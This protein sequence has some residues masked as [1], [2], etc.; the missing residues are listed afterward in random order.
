MEFWSLSHL[1]EAVKVGILNVGCIG[2]APLIDYLIDER[3]EIEDIEVRIVGTGSKM[4]PDKALEASQQLSSYKPTFAIVISP[5]ASLPGPKIAR[6]TLLKA[7]IPTIVVSDSPARRI[8]KDLESSGFGYVILEADAMIGAR[9]EFLD[10]NE[11][12]FFNG[13]VLRVLAITGSLR[14]A[15][16][17]LDRVVAAAKKGEKISLPKLFVDQ[18]R[19]LGESGLRNPYAVAKAMAAHE[20]A[21]RVSGISSDACFV[22]KEWE[23]YTPMV[24]SAHEMMRA[25]ARLADEAREIEKGQDTVLR[26][27]H[28]RDGTLLHKSRLMEK[29]A[30]KKS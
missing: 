19:A 13:D 27:P 9:R 26:Q 21:R 20:I 2:T 7:G 5:N 15:I 14:A 28:G 29:P 23:K 1:S 22:V 16:N 25:A 12:A 8:V 24:A 6:E 10:P 11:V 18:E 3:A 17:A 4:S 30:A